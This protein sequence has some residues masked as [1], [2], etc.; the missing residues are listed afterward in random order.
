MHSHWSPHNFCGEWKDALLQGGTVFMLW[1]CSAYHKRALL[2][3]WVSS[4]NHNRNPYYF[5]KWPDLSTLQFKLILNLVHT[6]TNPS[7]FPSSSTPSP[8]EPTHSLLSGLSSFRWVFW[9]GN[10]VCNRLCFILQISPRFLCATVLYKRCCGHRISDAKS[11]HC[12]RQ[13]RDQVHAGVGR[14]SAVKRRAA[15]DWP[16]KCGNHLFSLWLTQLDS[17]NSFPVSVPVH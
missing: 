11:A 13:S 10:S 9:C 7:Q 17:Q 6:F 15:Q 2:L 3:S 1:V 4:C 5:F 14:N 12:T 16:L 8:G